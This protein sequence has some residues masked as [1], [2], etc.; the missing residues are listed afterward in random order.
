MELMEAIRSRRSI[1][2]FEPKPIEPEKL[3]AVLEAGRLAPSASNRQEWRFVAVTD[4]DKRQQ[5]ARIANGQAFVGE[6]AAVIVACATECQHVMACGQY[7]YP[8]DVAI[9]VDHLT[10]KAVEEG[11][12]TCWI[13]AFQEEDVKNLLG[14]PDHVRVVALLPIGYPA[15]V[16]GPTYRKEL[17]EI[18]SY[19]GW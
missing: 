12:G 1:R 6:A 14:I 17:D 10:L 4:A 8:I 15:R 11:L 3:R 18:V 5:L 13:G 9:A 2:S 7:A 19:E 16:P